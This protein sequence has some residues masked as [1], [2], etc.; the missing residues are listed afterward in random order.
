MGQTITEK[1]LSRVIGRKVS[2]GDIVHPVP[3]LMT[4]HDW[5][6]ANFDKALQEFGVTKLFDPGRVL[7]STDHEPLAVTPQSSERQKRVREIVEKYGIKQFYDVGRGGLGHIFP[8]EEGIVRPGMFVE[9]YDVHVT[10]FGAV[11]VLAIPLVVEISEALALGSVWL[12]VPETVRVNASGRL[13]SGTS[14]RD[15]AQKL[16][17]DLGDALVDYTVV[18]FG[19]PGMLGI[20]IPGRQ[21][22]CNTPIDIGAKSALVEPDETTRQYVA[23]RYDGPLDMVTSDRDAQFRTLVEYDLST[24]GPQVAI[25]PTPDRVVGI[26]SVMGRKIQHAFVGSCASG[27]LPDLRDA[28]R[29]LAGRQVHS[30]VRLYVT[31]ATQNVA[32]AAANEGLMEIFYES[33][34]LVTSPGCGP[35][36]GGR[37]GALAE[38]EVSI[39]TGT[40]NDYG[41]L[42]AKTA[43]IYLAS[44]LTVAASAV[45]GKIADPR[46]YV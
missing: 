26:E 31:P 44:P 1:I 36:A 7:I 3:E 10:N 16:I 28:A 29:I 22:L 6:V 46:R 15:V 21:T 18:E 19:G 40:R 25:P 12:R 35:C 9:A 37:V 33:G 17:A 45:E 4:V 30:D 41:R 39:N 27:N 20:D 8:I 38:G 24:I 2:V 32:K 43:E 42:V 23:Q 11:G 14:I 5:Y 13:A 34:C